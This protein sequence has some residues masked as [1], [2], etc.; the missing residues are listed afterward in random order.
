LVQRENTVFQSG[1]LF[2]VIM[3]TIMSDRNDISNDV[4]LPIF[5]EDPVMAGLIGY[6]IV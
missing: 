3:L 5:I 4:H 6:F 2:I 1:K